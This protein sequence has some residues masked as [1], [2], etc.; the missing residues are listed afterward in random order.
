MHPGAAEAHGWEDEA[1][2][3]LDPA[4]RRCDPS[5]IVPI[6]YGLPGPEL[7][8][9]AERGDIVLGGCCIEE[10]QPLWRCLGCGDEFPKLDASDWDFPAKWDD[11]TD[12]DSE[13]WERAD[14]AEQADQQRLAEVIAQAAA[15]GM[16]RTDA[17]LDAFKPERRRV[18]LLEAIRRHSEPS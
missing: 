16:D 3:L 10:Y 1:M 7:M 11:W 17:I 2:P 12:D 9:E 6:V 14:I 15:S 18:F 5:K 8:E 13:A 4:C